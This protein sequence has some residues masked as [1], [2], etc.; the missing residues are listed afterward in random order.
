L[1]LNSSSYE[2]PKF[3]TLFCI[4]NNFCIKFNR[5]LSYLD[6]GHYLIETQGFYAKDTKTQNHPGEDRGFI[7]N[8]SR[9]FYI[10]WAAKRVSNDPSHSIPVQVPRLDRINWVNRYLMMAAGSEI[11]GCS[12]FT[13]S[14]ILIP[15]IRPNGQDLI[16]SKR[17][18]RSDLGR[19][20]QING[21]QPFTLLS[22]PTTAPRQRHIGTHGGAHRWPPSRHAD[23]L[24]LKPE[25]P[26]RS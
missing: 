4:K 6:C 26:T 14:A 22:Y 20:F 19:T 7:L 10:R 18:A 12:T 21:N 17:Y 23:A 24:F 9:G 1:E 5:F 2:F 13:P 11:H 15:R 3:G 8:K 25:R 16:S